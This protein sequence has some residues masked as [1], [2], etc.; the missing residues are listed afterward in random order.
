MK[1]DEGLH[2]GNLRGLMDMNAYDSSNDPEVLFE[3]SQAFLTRT[4]EV[5]D[6]LLQDEDFKEAVINKV[7]AIHGPD[8][9][10]AERIED[11]IGE[12]IGPGHALYEGDTGV[13]LYKRHIQKGLNVNKREFDVPVPEED[14]TDITY[15]NVIPGSVDNVDDDGSDESLGKANDILDDVLG[16]I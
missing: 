7:K 12:E 10:E 1:F 8:S 13:P 11:V 6:E 15:R 2:A 14:E 4:E 16:D 5:L 9:V 3:E